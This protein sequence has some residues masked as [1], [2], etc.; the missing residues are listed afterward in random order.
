ML[1]LGE[2][3]E[4]PQR[5]AGLEVAQRLPAFADL[6][7][8]RAAA[9]EGQRGRRLAGAEGVGAAPDGTLLAR[10]G[11]DAHAD[12]AELTQEQR[13]AQSGEA[14]HQAPRPCIPASLT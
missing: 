11:E 14:I 6:H 10:F 5:I 4:V 8:Q 1:A 9:D 13:S 7:L 2:Q 3:C 12:V